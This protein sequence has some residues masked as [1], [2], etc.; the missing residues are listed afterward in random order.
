MRTLETDNVIIGSGLAGVLVARELAAAGQR[1]TIVERGSLMTWDEQIRLGRWQEDS[2]TSELN[3]ENDPAGLDYPW[4]YVYG[5]GGST[6]RWAGTSPRF[7]P[8]DFEVKSRYGIMRDWPLSY[9]ELAPHYHSAER[10]MGVAGGDNALTPDTDYPLPPHPF[11]GQDRVVAPHLKPMVPLPQARPTKAVGKRAACCGSGRCQ[12]CPVN[13]RFSVLNAL[14]EVFELPEVEL[15]QKTVAAKLVSDGSGARVVAVE[16]LGEG[17][18]RLR[19]RAKRFVVAANGIESAGLMQRSGIVTGDTGLNL[20]DHY[21]SKLLVRVDRDAGPGIGSS[22]VTAAIYSYY[23]GDFRRTRAGVLMLPFNPGAPIMV[24]RLVDG[25]ADG[26]KGLSFRRDVATEWRQTLALD[27][28]VDDR[29]NPRNR[30]TLSAKKD[31]LG[32]PLNH[33][34]YEHPSD[35]WQRGVDH[36]IADVPRRLRALGAREARY[37]G[38][39]QGAHL[40]GTLRMGTDDGA[41]VDRHQRHRRRENLFVSG[42]A[43]F[44]TYS[45]SHPT[46]TIG[47]LSI[48]LGR[49]MASESV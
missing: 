9:A 45:P 39:P 3:H 21:N 38:A 17:G 22:L 31:S 25:L 33:V 10:A 35:Y 20:F 26:R 23:S 28:Y 6:N 5:V 18:E 4:T 44:P 43:V 15:M 27:I 12:L 7:L 47:A 16:C 30:V 36:V 40:L 29:P 32:L 2:P 34:R 11:G 46:L 49:Y 41:V 42:G 37:F 48:R 19:I 14:A 24:D 8:E 13:A 1:C